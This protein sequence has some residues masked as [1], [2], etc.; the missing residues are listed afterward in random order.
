[1]DATDFLLGG[2]ASMGATLFTNPLE[3]GVLVI[4]LFNCRQVV[5]V[6]LREDVKMMKY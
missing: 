5:L 2:V 4:T 3:V 6:L 1:M